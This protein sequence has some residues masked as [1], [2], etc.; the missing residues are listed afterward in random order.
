MAVLRLTLIFALATL[1]LA[2]AKSGQKVRKEAVQIQSAD[3]F[4]PLNYTERVT[5]SNKKGET[6]PNAAFL[7]N[8]LVG[9]TD[10]EAIKYVDDTVENGPPAFGY[11]TVERNYYQFPA[12]KIINQIIVESRKND[13]HGT[14]AIVYGGVGYSFVTLKFESELWRSLDYSIK[15]YAV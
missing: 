4:L 5:F 13:H 3:Q 9:I 14:A 15:I 11:V 8:I 12:G 6:I 10:P 7:N 2:F 1:T